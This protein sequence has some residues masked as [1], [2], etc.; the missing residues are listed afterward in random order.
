MR[1]HA[2]EPLRMSQV[3]AAAGCS[4]RTLGAVFPCFRGKTPLGVLQ[5]I[6][7]EKAHREL[8]MAARGQTV[9]AIARRH[10][11][12]N[13]ARFTAAFRRRY[14][15]APSEILHRAWRRQG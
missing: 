12:T 14:G 10:G 8:C 6:R 7:L 15:D 9:G 2:A 4:V 3:A 5:A 1:A 13:A 11:F